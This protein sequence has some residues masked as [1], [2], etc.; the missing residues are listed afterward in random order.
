MQTDKQANAFL[1]ILLIQIGIPVSFSWKPILVKVICGSRSLNK[2][3]TI[4]TMLLLKN[5]CL[6]WTDFIEL[7]KL[8]EIKCQNDTTA[9]R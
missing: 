2:I 5:T 6:E 9:S 8:L 1:Y 4:S 3:P 7:L